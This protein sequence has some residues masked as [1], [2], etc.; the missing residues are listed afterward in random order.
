MKWE[1]S[2]T[3]KPLRRHSNSDPMYTLFPFKDPESLAQQR[4]GLW[5]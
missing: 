2:L 1:F 4:F 3:K 5:E